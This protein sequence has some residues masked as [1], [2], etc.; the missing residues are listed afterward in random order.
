MTTII[1]CQNQVVIE[2]SRDNVQDLR[3]NRMFDNG[4]VDEFLGMFDICFSMILL[5]T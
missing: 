1:F 3:I 4:W 2:R 5:I